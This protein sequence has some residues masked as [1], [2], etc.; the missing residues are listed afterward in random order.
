MNIKSVPKNQ[1]STKYLACGSAPIAHPPPPD[2]SRDV[3][4]RVLKKTTPRPPPPE[5][6]VATAIGNR[7]TLSRAALSSDP[8][9]TDIND[10]SLLVVAEPAHDSNDIRYPTGRGC[11]R[12]WL[13]CCPQ[14]SLE[15]FVWQKDWRQRHRCR[16]H[17]RRQVGILRNAPGTR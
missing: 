17:H 8:A 11:R 2:A 15:P 13:A 3:L 9:T 1:V 14:G 16:R 4:E 10:N 5:H 7:C 12:C 6:L